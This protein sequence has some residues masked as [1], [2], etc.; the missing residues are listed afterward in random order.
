MK[1]EDVVRVS[2]KKNKREF[3]HAFIAS[4]KVIRAK[5]DPKAAD[6]LAVL[7]YKHQYWSEKGKLINYKGRNG[8]YISIDNIREETCFGKNAIQSSIRL[9]KKEGLIDSKRQGLTMPNIY[10]ID[11]SNITKY[12]EDHK[13]DYERWRFKVRKEKVTVLSVDTLKYKNQHSRNPNSNI[14]DMEES[15]ITK[16]KITNNKITKTLTNHINVEKELDYLFDYTNELE[17][18]IGALNNSDNETDR[19]DCIKD[20]YNFLCNMVPKFKGFS[21]SDEDHALITELVYDGASSYK[22][23]DI[24]IRN[25]QAI[26]Y[27]RKATRFGNL[28]VGLKEMKENKMQYE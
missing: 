21:M 22:I 6:V 9:L 16:N 1:K 3:E 24:I 2:K 27:G 13:E 25:A 28:F 26:C 8:F 5:L 19:Y 7:Q 12:I 11:E 20:T 17:E 10:F 4:S 14:L 15:A 23:A 18:K